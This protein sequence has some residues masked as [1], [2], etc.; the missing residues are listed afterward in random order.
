MLCAGCTAKTAPIISNADSNDTLTQT[1][2]PTGK[3]GASVSLTHQSPKTWIA[4][5]TDTIKLTFNSTQNTG[6]MNVTVSDAHG[7]E[8]I[9]S[10]T[11]GFDLESPEVKRAD[12]VV[13]PPH[14]GYYQ[15]D[16]QI[17]IKS[18][19]SERIRIYSIPINVGDTPKAKKS[20][21]VNGEVVMPAIETYE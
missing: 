21:A 20:S 13:S 11:F 15:L 7:L 10:T 19:N 6:Q 16:I 8:I 2:T 14:D 17:T 3:P 12:I 1:L 18:N 5:N 9:G 4:G